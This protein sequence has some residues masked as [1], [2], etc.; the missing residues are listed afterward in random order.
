MSTSFRDI[1]DGSEFFDVT[2]CCDDG[3]TRL[4]AHRVVLAACSPLLRRVLAGSGPQSP[5]LLFLK[6]VD[7]ANL[8]AVLDFMYHGEVNVA[9][10]DLAAFLRVAEE[11]AVKGLTD[12]PDN[13]EG[14]KEAKEDQQ[15]VNRKSYN[16]KRPLPNT[17]P[18][19]KPGSSSGVQ[20]PL[21]SSKKRKL[22]PSSMSSSGFSSSPSS[23]SLNVKSEPSPSSSKAPAPNELDGTSGDGFGGE[24]E[25]DG[26]FGFDDYGGGGD[27]SGGGDFHHHMGGAGS[28]APT[29]QGE[30]VGHMEGGKGE[31]G[32]TIELALITAVQFM[33]SLRRSRVFKK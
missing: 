27:G 5:P 19:L 30:M 3:D 23:S 28:M 6:G 4:Q 20:N 32:Y 29:E 25:E 13:K 18:P 15:L 1:R 8:S 10:T 7:G 33:C 12:K 16:V 9:Q 2:L 26:D 21:L 31:A 24:D 14:D 11:L 22:E 17:T